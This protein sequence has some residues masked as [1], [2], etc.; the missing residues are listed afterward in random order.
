MKT[1]LRPLIT[2]LVLSL[3]LAFVYQQS[4]AVDVQGVQK[5]QHLLTKIEAFEHSL[6]RDML[7]IRNGELVHYDTLKYARQHMLTAE[8]QL[9]AIAPQQA[10]AACA[11]LTQ[12]IHRQNASLEQFMADQSV[13]ANS[14]RF[15]PKA[16]ALAVQAEP[17]HAS[18]LVTLHRDI[19]EYLRGSSPGLAQSIRSDVKGL[20]AGK[21]LQRHIGHILS[22]NYSV[23]LAIEAFNDGGVLQQTGLLHKSLEEYLEAGVA[24]MELYQFWLIVLALVLIAYIGWVVWQQTQIAVSLRQ[25]LGKIET[26]Q[27]ALDEHAIVGITDQRG[28]II[29]A[30]DK[31]CE[32][33]GYD[34][35]EL[36]GK[37]HRILNSAYHDKAFFKE[38]WRTIAG[39]EV[40]H[41]VIRNQRKD[42]SHYWVDTS[43]VPFLNDE[44]KPYQYV[45]IRTDVTRIVEQEEEQ[46]LHQQKLEH[47]QRL[48]SLGVLAGG[49]AHDFNNLL[50]AIMGNA[51]LIDRYLDIGS[52]AKD[53]LHRVI[54][55]A[56]KAA[57]L[58][59]QMLAYSGKGHF[60]VQ[61]CDISVL[62]EEMAELLMVS[63]DKNVVIKYELAENLPSIEGDV[64]QMHQVIMNL[65]TNANEAIHGKSGVITMATGWLH[66]DRT[67]LD[68]IV[69]EDGLSEGDYVYLEVSDNGCGMDKK[70][71]RKI[72]DPFFTT[73]FTGRGLG[74][75]ALHGIVRGHMGAIKVYS[76]LGRGTTFKILL[77]V[78]EQSHA[79][80]QSDVTAEEAV[81]KSDGGIAL[82]VDDEE[83]IREM[84]GA[85]LRDMGF[86]VLEAENGLEAVQLYPDHAQD[87]RVVLLDMSMPK[88]DGETTFR[89]LRKL[90]P[91]VRVILSSGY[92]EQEAT[93]RFS[94]K[95]LAGF[96][97]KPYLPD[98]LQNAVEVALK[99]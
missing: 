26:Q 42:G 18:Q 71:L 46:R 63:I 31:F 20:Q 8:G 58:C 98:T 41:G 23:L 57:S 37:N 44:G 72:F 14:L 40:W 53:K 64:A 94:G 89:E 33:S 80:I 54:S 21:A 2:I 87:I 22:S 61:P 17:M 52:P 56:E 48:E 85:M 76:E 38:L 99:P 7:K 60:I 66:A 10:Q 90:N 3:L 36:L 88:M 19:L 73:K 32:I 24:R 77:P 50:T 86:D 34:R 55:A 29:Y 13:L 6:G 84:A 47:A 93:Q 75:S 65:I 39:G 91:E 51:G 59:K 62:V 5:A 78:S 1:L 74:M 35:E 81:W 92:T 15:L 25:A 70:T 43:I 45:S 16:I 28:D 67:Y 12:L 4:Q 27:L 79:A 11:A 97:Q 83:M 30:N 96:V 9:K 82:V 49:I 69:S 68:N 95:G